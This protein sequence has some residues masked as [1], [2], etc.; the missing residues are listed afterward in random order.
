MSILTISKLLQL[1][2]TSTPNLNHSQPVMAPSQCNNPV[3]IID[4]DVE[5]NL[6]E[7]FGEVAALAADLLQD[8]PEELEGQHELRRLA[9]DIAVHLPTCPEETVAAGCVL[10]YVYF[11]CQSLHCSY[12]EKIRLNI[13]ESWLYVI[14]FLP[15]DRCSFSTRSCRDE[16]FTITECIN[17]GAPVPRPLLLQRD[18]NALVPIERTFAH[19]SNEM[20][21]N[22]RRLYKEGAAYEDEPFLLQFDSYSPEHRV[23]GLPE[24]ISFEPTLSPDAPP[25]AAQHLIHDVNGDILSIRGKL[26]MEDREAILSGE[27][28][29]MPLNSDLPLPQPLPSRAVLGI[30]GFNPFVFRASTNNE[31][32][33][34]TAPTQDTEPPISSTSSNSSAVLHATP[35]S[36]TPLS[37]VHNSAIPTPSPLSDD[38]EEGQEMNCPSHSPSP[39]GP[40]QPIVSVRVATLSA[41]SGPISPSSH[42]IANPFSDAGTGDRERTFAFDVVLNTSD[43][44]NSKSP[45]SEPTS[46]G[47]RK[48]G[49]TSDL[50]PGS[51]DT[52]DKS[53]KRQR[54]IDGQPQQPPAT[55]S[56]QDGHHPT[57]G[58]GMY[59]LYVYAVFLIPTCLTGGPPS[60]RRSSPTSGNR[61][62]SPP[63]RTFKPMLPYNAKTGRKLRR[64][65]AFV[66]K[67]FGK[68]TAWLPNPHPHAYSDDPAHTS[69]RPL[70]RTGA[71][72]GFNVGKRVE[73]F[74]R[75]PPSGLYG[76]SYRDPMPSASTTPVNPASSAAAFLVQG[77]GTNDNVQR[78]PS[79]YNPVLPSFPI[80]EGV[81]ID[82]L[83][84]EY[85]DDPSLVAPLAAPS[86][87]WVL[88]PMPETPT[89]ASRT[90]RNNGAIGGR[91]PSPSADTR[92]RSHGDEEDED[93]SLRPTSRIRSFSVLLPGPSRRLPM[94]PQLPRVLPAAASSSSASPQTA[95]M[96]IVQASPE[97]P[98]LR[99]SSRLARAAKKLRK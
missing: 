93:E 92:K 59:L 97:S 29:I 8:W 76:R 69:G 6:Y 89:P 30:Q 37:A 77:S 57:F 53:P 72:I 5:R 16:P 47:T 21:L 11:E 35:S 68:Y 44:S 84:L 2:N 4:D 27:W 45:H 58:S 67:D 46:L 80:P 70:K 51:N 23:I 41:P 65:G 18:N 75:P 63:P 52:D 90:R 12:R 55:T 98:P 50:G 83:E 87:S 78:P 71:G 32:P 85:V 39:P 99:R 34:S 26:T 64:E 42:A 96:P 9:E 81:V 86:S 25:I 38:R 13:T 91:A 19:A 22:R 28:T 74:P 61:Q 82:D 40:D 15:C 95:T 43:T 3:S 24:I 33:T 79:P 60:Q 10:I 14:P 1:A 54:G 31:N 62:S 49:L 94:L 20:P 66:E 7:S 73:W 88:P 48:R 56:T 36:S 17:P